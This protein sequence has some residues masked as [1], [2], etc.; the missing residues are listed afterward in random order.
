MLQMVKKVQMYAEKVATHYDP[1]QQSSVGGG[2]VITPHSTL[3]KLASMKEI[4]CNGSITVYRENFAPRFIC[5]FSPSGL[6]ANLKLGQLR[7][8]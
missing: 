4:C 7:Y 8:I 5:A 1:P 6:R 3:Q 2:G